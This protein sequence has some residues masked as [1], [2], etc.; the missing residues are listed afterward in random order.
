[1]TDPLEAVV[2]GVLMNV[3]SSGGQS[4]VQTVADTFAQSVEQ[5]GVVLQRAGEQ[6]AAG[7]WPGELVFDRQV[8]EVIHAWS[9]P[10]TLDNVEQ[11]V[12]MIGGSGDL[13][14]KRLINLILNQLDA[15]WDQVHYVADRP[16]NDRRYSMSWGKIASLGYRPTQGFE[17][18]LAQT[19]RWYRDHPDWWGTTA[20][21]PRRTRSGDPTRYP[22]GDQPCPLIEWPH[23]AAYS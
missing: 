13:T 21:Q 9:P 16:S 18:A 4:P 10:Q 19:V 1:M 11:F 23:R 12:H 8:V 15:D 14:N 20:P 17:D 6:V 22:L 5:L 7:T 3:Q 2:D